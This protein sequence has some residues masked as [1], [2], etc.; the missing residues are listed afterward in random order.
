MGG[1]EGGRGGD[2]SPAQ[3]VGSLD[4]ALPRRRRL[5]VDARPLQLR[6][7]HGA[8]DLAAADVGAVVCARRA[9]LDASKGVICRGVAKHTS[10]HLATVYPTHIPSTAQ[11]QGDTR[12]TPVRGNVP[13]RIRLHG[14]AGDAPLQLEPGGLGRPRRCVPTDIDKGSSSPSTNTAR[15]LRRRPR[16]R[17]V[18]A[19]S[20]GRG[21]ERQLEP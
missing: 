3:R 4:G 21:Q 20:H 18:V 19:A 6:G 14:E 10:V 17:P 2:F 7:A 9:D 13:A 16:T 15:L 5:V 12:L 8:P 1:E 11:E